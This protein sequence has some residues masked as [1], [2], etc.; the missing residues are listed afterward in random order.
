M[1]DLKGKVAFITGAASGI[2]LGM[3]QAFAAAG[4]KVA[5]VDVRN[6]VLQAAAR[7]LST[8]GAECLAIQLDV[9]D[10]AAWI[11]AVDRVE[12]ALGNIQVLCSNAGVNFVGPLQD[13]TWQDWDFCL[14]VNVGGAINAVRTVV[15][16]ML[17]RAAAQLAALPDE[18]ID[19]ARVNATQRLFDAS[20]YAGQ[21]AKPPP[22]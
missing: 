5:L 1:N 7:M 12:H 20:L 16:R 10:R 9:T 17:A 13:A 3:A 22:R 6:N 18:P 21:S 2:G 14:G 11:P 19:P 8:L 4:M 15:P